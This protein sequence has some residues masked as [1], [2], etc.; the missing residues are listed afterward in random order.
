MYVIHGSHSVFLEEERKIIKVLY[1]RVNLK[2]SA[3][4]ALIWNG[5]TKMIPSPKVFTTLLNAYFYWQKL[6]S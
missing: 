3:V 2:L 5:P 6:S 4:R 1:K